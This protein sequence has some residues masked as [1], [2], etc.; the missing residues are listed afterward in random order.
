MYNTYTGGCNILNLQL[1]RHKSID[2][3]INNSKTWD[4]TNPLLPNS[5]ILQQQQHH[6]QH[7]HQRG[8]NSGFDNN[9][10]MDRSSN[11]KNN[12][13][14]EHPLLPI[15][16]N[17]PFQNTSNSPF[18][19]QQ[20]QSQH[21]QQQQLQQMMNNSSLSSQQQQ[22]AM[23]GG[24]PNGNSFMNSNVVAAQS[25]YPMQGMDSRPAVLQ[26]SNFPD[27]VI[28]SLLDDIFILFL[29]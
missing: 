26:V 2:V 9:M 18:M 21:H 11:Q 12:M 15:P 29:F 4:Y 24:G 14:A 13:I 5:D 27:Q 16:M 17:M 7:Q 8:N 23:L 6:Q 1:S 19:G 28:H 25:G 20:Q 10:S 22:Q 3:K